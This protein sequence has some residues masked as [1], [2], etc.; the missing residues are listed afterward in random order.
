MGNSRIP[1]ESWQ[2]SF[3]QID[4][5]D[6]ADCARQL[7]EGI[8]RIEEVDEAVLSFVT[9]KLHL[10]FRGSLDPIRRLVEAHGYKLLNNSVSGADTVKVRVRHALLSAL[11]LL[12]AAAAGQI[13]PQAAKFFLFMTVLIGGHLTFQRSFV[14]LKQHRLDMNV[15]M[16]TAVTGAL[17]ID[18]WWEAA[19]V[20]FLF[21][22]S[23]ALETYTAEKNRNSIRVL[24]NTLPE[25]AHL[26]VDGVPETV[27]AATVKTGA[28]IL[29]RPG[30][31]VPL[32]GMVLSGLSYAYEAAVTG[33]S[34]PA[35][36]QPGT[37]VYAGT[38]NGNGS[39]QVKVTGSAQDSTLSKIV[40]LVEAAQ[41]RR[42]PSQQFIDRFARF[43]TPAVIFFAVSIALFGPL[44]A[45][46]GWE[47]WFY[48]SLA[49]LI[50]ACP[51][52]LVVST[53]VTIVAA[54][55]NAARK[56][57]L[58][59]GGLYLE[60]MESVNAVLFDKTGT[61]TQGKPVVIRQITYGDFLPDRL[62][63]VAA[64]LEFN[65]EHLLADAV[66]K[67]A[68]LRETVI[69]D[70]EAFTAF[71]GKGVAGTIANKRY[72]L[73]ST[74]FLAVE[75]VAM[76]ELDSTPAGGETVLALASEGKLLGALFVSDTIRQESFAVISALRD[77]GIEKIAML[78]GDRDAAARP[79]A[80]KLGIVDTLTSLLPEE[81]EEIVR[82][83]RQDYGKVAMV[84]DGINDAPALASANVGIVMGA[85]GSPTALESADIAL[86]SDDLRK[87]P[88][89][90]DLSRKT[91]KVV[92]QNIAI[93]L[94]M[95]G[96][97]IMLAF[98][99]WLSLWFAILADMGVS[100]LV[101]MNGMRLLVY[102]SPERE[103]LEPVK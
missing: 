10:R 29:I 31:T 95:K 89:L 61:L 48:R 26:L 36:K 25:S 8:R 93:A 57:I 91:V 81:K 100:L 1:A 67:Y 27:L 69:L 99:G 58:I 49:L 74:D 16:T 47:L 98:P 20:A 101:T 59:K 72:L 70:V 42:P 87:I 23:H 96:L 102:Q 85:A 46:G 11:T 14:A 82:K 37:K 18:E 4:G 90:I 45:Q 66:R 13:H 33:E 5:L 84:G 71:P 63:Q 80:E 22:A 43:Y 94:L 32:D 68:A 19:I 28:E 92:R 41:E 34:L 40:R 12:L 15:L 38:L 64:S 79:L 39:L 3:C 50:V 51:C 44:V 76:D 24:M 62:V 30:E 86:L 55:T 97:V 73:G 2:E 83:I 88:F 52:A 53:P 54:L 78:T 6:C 103:K 7:E 75:G 21:A 56:G 60:E 9:G 17:I 35:A 77:M 65:S